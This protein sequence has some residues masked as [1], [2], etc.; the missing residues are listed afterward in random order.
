MELLSPLLIRPLPLEEAAYSSYFTLLFPLQEPCR[1]GNGVLRYPCLFDCQLTLNEDGTH[2]PAQCSKNSER[3]GRHT[4]PPRMKIT[5]NVNVRVLLNLT[6]RKIW[7][8]FRF[9]S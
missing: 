1:L 8:C 9:F 5:V 2:Y 4:S 3:E 6:Q 7:Q